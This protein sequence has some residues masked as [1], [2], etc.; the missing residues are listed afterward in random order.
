MVLN[1]AVYNIAIVSLKNPIP[2]QC[3]PFADQ[4][5]TYRRDSPVCIVLE[6]LAHYLWGSAIENQHFTA[7][8]EDSIAHNGREREL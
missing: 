6:E 4:Y 5:T 1:N 3:P 7:L 8:K 2:T